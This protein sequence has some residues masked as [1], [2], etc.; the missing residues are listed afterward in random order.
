M[1]CTEFDCKFCRT[2]LA[3]TECGDPE[4]KMEF[5][6]IWDRFSGTDFVPVA[7]GCWYVSICKIKSTINVYQTNIYVQLLYPCTK[8]TLAAPFNYFHITQNS[9]SKNYQWGIK[10]HGI[11]W[12]G[13]CI[14]ILIAIFPFERH[15]LSNSSKDKRVQS[16][17]KLHK[18]SIFPKSFVKHMDQQTTMDDTLY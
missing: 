13:T 6:I 12:H 3:F 1:S 14:F 8:E 16:T 18:I 4:Y 15:L 9:L 11:A 7:L 2:W 17:F 10:L 5:S